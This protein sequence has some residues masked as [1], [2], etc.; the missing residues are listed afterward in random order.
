MSDFADY[1]LAM[2]NLY[3][4]ED[5]KAYLND[6]LDALDEGGRGSRA[7]MSRA[8]G[9]QT[10]YTARVLRGA[11]HFSLEQAEGINDFL[12][13]SEDQGHY[14][15]LL[16]QWAKAGH[17]KLRSRFQGLI[18]EEQDS[19]NLLKHRLSAKEN[20]DERDR[21]MFYSSWIYPAVHALISV[22]GF[23]T[24]EKIS[25][26]LKVGIKQSV[27]AIEFLT[28]V[29]L[30]ESTKNGTLRIG[31]AQTHLG[32]DS[33]LIAKHHTSWRMQAIRAIEDDPQRGLH[34]SSVV[35]LSLKDYEAIREDLIEAIRRAKAVIRDSPEEEV[36][37]LSLD[38]FAL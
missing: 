8:I 11:A 34:Y 36:C 14:F 16:V 4:Y 10:A 31:K 22:P 24:P 12:G 29:G 20:L 28:N 7:Q 6:K 26:R 17:P 19:R 38:F 37:C 23:Q 27:S 5:Y 15:L 35:S 18:K 32:A 25:Q 1:K 21:V 30:V 2:Q 13:H 3:A 33:P 9:C